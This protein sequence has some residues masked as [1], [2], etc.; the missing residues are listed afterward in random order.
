MGLSSASAIRNRLSHLRGGNFVR[1]SP[2]G[3]HTVRLARTNLSGLKVL[4]SGVPLLNAIATKTPVLTMRRTASCF[5]IPPSLRSGTKSLFVL[6]VHKR[7]VVSTNVFSNSSIVIEGRGATRGKSVIVTVASS[8][9]TAYG[10]FCGRGGCCHL[11]PR[12]SDVSPVVL[13]SILVLNGMINLCQGRV[14]W[15]AIL[16]LARGNYRPTTFLHICTCLKLLLLMFRRH[17]SIVPLSRVSTLWVRRL[18]RRHRTRGFSTWFFGRFCDH[19]Y[20]TTDDRRVVAS[21][22]FVT[23]RSNILVRLRYHFPM[24]RPMKCFGYFTKRFT[25]F[26]NRHRSTTWFRDRETASRRTAHF[27][28]SC[29]VGVRILD[30]F[31]SFLS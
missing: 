4:S 23:E 1:Q 26:T 18:S 13:S 8:S 2:A 5:P 27:E 28:S 22:R 31:R 20:D 7:D 24:F 11:R 17:R 16:Q 9:R 12:G 25:F 10:H 3:P 14:V 21:R 15:E 30:V 19:N 6:G 29:F